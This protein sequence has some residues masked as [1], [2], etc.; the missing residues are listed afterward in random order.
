MA[1]QK[2]QGGC[3][4]H[5]AFRNV[6]VVHKSLWPDEPFTLGNSSVIRRNLGTIELTAPEICLP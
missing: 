5:R 1:E 4:A 6:S 3:D 2:S